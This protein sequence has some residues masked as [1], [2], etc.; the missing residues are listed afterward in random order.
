MGATCGAA[1]AYPTRTP[2]LTPVLSGVCVDRS[3]IFGV[4]FYVSLFPFVLLLNTP[5]VSSMFS[6]DTL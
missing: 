4:M 2:E 3:L 6:Y 5:S 1:I